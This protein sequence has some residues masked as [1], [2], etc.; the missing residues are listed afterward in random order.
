M[1][2]GI[3]KKVIFISFLFINFIQPSRSAELS[4]IN[5]DINNRNIKLTS[6]KASNFDNSSNYQDKSLSNNFDDFNDYVKFL[7]KKTDSLLVAKVENQQEL[8]IQ[9]DKQSEISDVIYAE[10]N[11]SVSYKGKLF[12][13]DKLIYDK[14][15]QKIE[16]RGNIT[17]ILGDQIFRVSQLEYS[18]IS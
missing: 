16:A 8:I 3:S 17:F 5:K 14:L 7:K 13:A 11:V 15:N 10:G 18:F 12:K 6:S 1:I 9:S 2:L 4:T